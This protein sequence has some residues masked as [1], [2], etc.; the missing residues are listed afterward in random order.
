M[1]GLQP[2]NRQEL[3]ALSDQQLADVGR[4]LGAYP[5]IDLSFSLSSDAVRAGEEF[6]VEVHMT[7]TNLPEGASVPPVQ[8]PR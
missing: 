8:A 1:R 2:D 3:L 4:T 7:R 6:T 5:D